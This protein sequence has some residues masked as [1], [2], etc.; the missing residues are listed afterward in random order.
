MNGAIVPARGASPWA[1]VLVAALLGYVMLVLVSR[2]P[3]GWRTH[4]TAGA[5][6]IAPS[7]VLWA[8]ARSQLGGA[9]TPRAEARSL[10]TTGIYSRI[11]HPIYVFAET[12]TVGLCVFADISLFWLI[13][14]LAIPIQVV[15]ARREERILEAAFGDEYRRYRDRTW[16]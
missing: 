8:L 10:V 14:P 15:C 1:P 11:R 12:L 7:L 2:S 6:F 3:D 4:H 16:F 9:F 13:I 5:F